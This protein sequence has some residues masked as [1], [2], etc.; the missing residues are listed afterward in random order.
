MYLI[1]IVALHNSTDF[2]PGATFLQWFTSVFS[3]YLS[4]FIQFCIFTKYTR[5]Q[6][7]ENYVPNDY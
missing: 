4:S 5:M 7:S 1:I 3:D 2:L 6:A